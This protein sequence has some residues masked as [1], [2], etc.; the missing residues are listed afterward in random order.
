MIEVIAQ[1]RAEWLSEVREAWLTWYF[2]AGVL[3]PPALFLIASRVLWGGLI[4][5]PLAIGLFWLFFTLGIRNVS[6]VMIE[7]ALTDEEVEFACADTARNLAPF[8]TV[9]PA[10]VV[11]SVLALGGVSFLRSVFRAREN[12]EESPCTN[13]GRINGNSTHI[14]PRCMKSTEPPIRYPS[15]NLTGNF[16]NAG[17]RS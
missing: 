3:I 5:L 10:A 12:C 17:P 4:A 11:Y 7:A 1:L 15:N 13:C 16:T 9:P 8:L 14:C 6:A 2:V